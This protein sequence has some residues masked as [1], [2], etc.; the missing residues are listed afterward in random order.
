MIS[1]CSTR[2]N[3]S[4]RSTRTLARAIAD[5]RLG[6]GCDQV[7]VIAPAANG[8]DAAMRI[9]NADG[10]EVESCGNAARCVARLLMDEKGTGASPA[11]DRG[12]AAGLYRSGGRAGDRGYGRAAI[13]LARNPACGRG[14]Y[15]PLQFCG[16]RGFNRGFGGFG[17]QSALRDLFV[18]DA[19]DAPVA[20]AGAT[21][22][23]PSAVSRAHQCRIRYRAI[24]RACCA[25]GC[26]NAASASHRPA[27]RAPAPWPLRRRGA[28]LTERKVEVVL[29]GGTLQIEWRESD[30]TCAD[31]RA[32]DAGLPAKSILLSGDGMSAGGRHLR[33]PAERL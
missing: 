9:Y 1:W 16:G 24:A 5:R 33:L 3:R 6:I 11:R 25:C 31:D 28:G 12:R 4:L 15:Q 19:E 17:G 20:E 30:G 18:D 26:G 21:D 13:G 8:A 27:A 14:R 29:D 23:E 2:A 7:I 32:R 22:R 10:G